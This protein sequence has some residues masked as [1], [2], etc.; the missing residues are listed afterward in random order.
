MQL[1]KSQK[2]L[3]P[4]NFLAE[5][6]EQINEFIVGHPVKKNKFC[7][8]IGKVIREAEKYGQ[9]LQDEWQ[10]AK[11]A[12][13]T[14]CDEKKD[15]Q[16]WFFWSAFTNDWMVGDSVYFAGGEYSGVQFYM[17][18]KPKPDP[19][20]YLSSMI[21]ACVGQEYE[22]LERLD[23]QFVL[24]AIIHD[25]QN[26]QAGRERIYFNPTEGEGLSDRLSRAAWKRLESYK[27]PYGFKDVR[28]T[29]ETAI[30]AVKANL[31]QEEEGQSNGGKVD[32]PNEKSSYSLF[33]RHHWKWIIGTSIA[34]IGASIALI[35]LIWSIM[36][37]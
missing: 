24:L 35:A 12:G 3:Y 17:E 5:V 15:K 32:S 2:Q 33:W 14:R 29:I 31:E 37:T 27:T 7:K 23:Y 22:G 1:S 9:Y 25:A 21:W 30:R 16:K 6:S 28:Q 8:H 4:K 20:C 11:E 18:G 13:L 10:K 36:N 26:W 19:L 34:L